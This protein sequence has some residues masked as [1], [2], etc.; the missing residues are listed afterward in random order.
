M[1]AR[2]DLNHV[3]GLIVCEIIRFAARILRRQF[4]LIF[5][6]IIAL[7]FLFAFS[8]GVLAAQPKECAELLGP[9][10]VKLLAEKFPGY[11]VPQLADLGQQYIDFE[12]SEG[13]NGC[14]SIAQ[15][16]FNGDHR[17]DFAIWLTSIKG[18]SLRLVVTFQHKKSWAADEIPAFCENVKYCYV[19][20]EKPGTYVR[21]N[22]LDSPPTR[23]DERVKLRSKTTSVKAGKWESTGIVYVYSKGHWNYVWISD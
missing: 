11:R 18:K 19:K 13:W 17:Q 6:S 2:L 1:I 20:P 15:G 12:L 9:D 10:L 14:Y 8:S 21:T 4:K 16:D 7:P 3:S 5:N 22:A 23:K